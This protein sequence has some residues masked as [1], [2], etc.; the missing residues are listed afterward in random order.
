MI[1]YFLGVLATLVILGYCY[2]RFDWYTT[3]GF[4]PRVVLIFPAVLWFIALPL[5]AL[6]LLLNYVIHL[7]EQKR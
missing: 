3:L 2:G 5:I 4:M 6:F 1:V 7:G